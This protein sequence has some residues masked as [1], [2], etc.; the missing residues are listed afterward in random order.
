M[1]EYD[2]S[3]KN[4]ASFLRD[5]SGDNENS[6]S[7]LTGLDDITK[8]LE[9]KQCEL[10]LSSLGKYMNEEFARKYDDWKEEAEAVDLPETL[11]HKLKQLT[12]KYEK[13]E[14]NKIKEK[15]RRKYIKVCSLVLA[16]AICA[17]GITLVESEALRERVYNIFFTPGDGH[18]TIEF[19]EIFGDVSI[20]DDVKA[21]MYPETLPV[22]Y[23]LTECYRDGDSINL[24]FTDI[25]TQDWVMLSYIEADTIL[26]IDTEQSDNRIIEINGQEAVIQNSQFS[27]DV[28]W[29]Y[30]EYSVE[31]T[32]SSEFF[33]ED[34]AIKMAE[35]IKFYSIDELESL[36]GLN[37]SE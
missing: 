26:D 34:E 32:C 24:V 6:S 7:G 4:G 37:Q 23:K 5:S 11:E 30:D 27:H 13:A 16:A 17:G 33:S 25:N 14:R 2:R 3:N 8:E 29:K 36:S 20:P 1:N 21:L 10:V 18:V 12:L 35:H 31:L 15:K 19:R 9:K 28:Y 22:N